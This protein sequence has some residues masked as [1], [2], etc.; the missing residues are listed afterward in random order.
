[1]LG[2]AAL[3]ATRSLLAATNMVL[4]AASEYFGISQAVRYEREILSARGAE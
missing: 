4:V 3:N 1:V 2:P